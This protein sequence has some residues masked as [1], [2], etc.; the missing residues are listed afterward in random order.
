MGFKVKNLNDP[1][2]GHPVYNTNIKVVEITKPKIPED[3][4]GVIN[5]SWEKVC[6]EGAYMEW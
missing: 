5:W 4:L 1:F 6:Y 2:L 3:A